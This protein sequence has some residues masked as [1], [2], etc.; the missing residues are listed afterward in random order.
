MASES[1]ATLSDAIFSFPESGYLASG[2]SA[3]SQ[4]GWGLSSQKKGMIGEKP[5]KKNLC[6]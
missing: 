3:F 1:V 4:H 5:T 6:P 2:N